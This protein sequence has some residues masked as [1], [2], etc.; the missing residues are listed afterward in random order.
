MPTSEQVVYLV[1]D[2]H[3]GEKVDVEDVHVCTHT[4]CDMFY[5]AHGRYNLHV[6]SQEAKHVLLHR[7]GYGYVH[8]C[9]HARAV[10][11]EKKTVTPV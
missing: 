3:N 8:E 7:K 10:H 4:Q 1:E 6:L 2:T 9:G 11:Y 5:W